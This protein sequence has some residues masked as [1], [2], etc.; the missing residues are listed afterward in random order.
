VVGSVLMLVSGG[1]VFDLLIVV[2]VAG[3]V[4][5]GSMIDLDQRR[6]SDVDVDVGLESNKYMHSR[7]EAVSF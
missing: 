1:V 3:G 5:M 7:P 6:P 2:L 4:G